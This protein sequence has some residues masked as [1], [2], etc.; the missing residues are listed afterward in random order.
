MAAPAAIHGILQG[1]TPVTDI[2]GNRLFTVYAP[3]ETPKPL[4]VYAIDDLRPTETKDSSRELDIVPVSL[5]SYSTS[6]DE[7]HD[8]MNKSRNALVRFSDTIN[9]TEIDS[10]ILES[11]KD[12]YDTD[13]KVY[14]GEQV[15][16]MRVK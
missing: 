1:A 3:V 7:L 16:K 4:Q 10:I 11:Q 9:S 6:Y 8:L 15:Y 14:W 12:G 2:I 5:M 13:S